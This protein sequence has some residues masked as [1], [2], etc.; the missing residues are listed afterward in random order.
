MQARRPPL[1]TTLT[2]TAGKKSKR[3]GPWPSLLTLRISG[4]AP[5]AFTGAAMVLVLSKNS[6]VNLHM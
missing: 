3:L 2:N 5:G 4:D 1:N 6:G